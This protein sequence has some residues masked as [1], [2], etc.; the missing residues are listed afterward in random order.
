H[1]G[2]SVVV[3]ERLGE[4]RDDLAARA[5]YTA[6][7]VAWAYMLAISVCYFFAPGMFLGGFFSSNAPLTP[8]QLAVREMATRLLQFVS[9]YNLFDATQMIFVGALKGAGDTR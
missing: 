5:T 9:A 8:E 4:D 2:V 3:G 7:Q 6:L 1:L